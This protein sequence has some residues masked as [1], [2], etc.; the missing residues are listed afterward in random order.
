LEFSVPFQ[1]KYGYIR[2][3]GNAVDTIDKKEISARRFVAHGNC[4]RGPSERSSASSANE[5][6]SR[7]R[8]STSPSGSREQIQ[9]AIL[10]AAV[11]QMSRVAHSLSYLTL[12][13][14]R[15]AS[16]ASLADAISLVGH[17]MIRV[18]GRPSPT[19]IVH[20]SS[21]IRYGV[22]TISPARGKCTAGIGRWRS[23]RI[24]TA[25]RFGVFDKGCVRKVTQSRLEPKPTVHKLLSAAQS[26]PETGVYERPV[27][28]LRTHRATLV[29]SRVRRCKHDGNI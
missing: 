10:G 23:S 2:D 28:A 9:R 18:R 19:V 8:P 25:F 24:A 3:E 7:A 14:R 27:Q 29:A 13:R 5:P 21:I 12:K 20:A 11:S 17:A 16:D 22:E 15:R 1:H 26:D 4:R 6:T